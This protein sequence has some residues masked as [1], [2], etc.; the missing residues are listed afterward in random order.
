M[1][2]KTAQTSVSLGGGILCV[3]P[4]SGRIKQ[5]NTIYRTLSTGEPKNGLSQKTSS[6][7]GP[8]LALSASHSRTQKCKREFTSGFTTK[9]HSSTQSACIFGTA[10]SIEALQNF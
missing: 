3:S 10:A 5:Q 9:T 2:G 1:V 6:L 7:N 8:K 4:N